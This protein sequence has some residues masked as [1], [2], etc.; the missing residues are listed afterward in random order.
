MSGGFEEIEI[1]EPGAAESG[2]LNPHQGGGDFDSDEASLES[3]AAIQNHPALEGQRREAIEGI[4]RAAIETPIRPAIG[5]AHGPL[6]VKESHSIQVYLSGALIN[7]LDLGG[8]SQ[9]VGK[10]VRTLQTPNRVSFR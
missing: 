4:T 3:L 9:P 10:R 5:A 6:V 8:A 2:A 1:D 7:S